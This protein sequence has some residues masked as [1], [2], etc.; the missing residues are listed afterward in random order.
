MASQTT[1]N[2]LEFVRALLDE[3]GDGLAVFAE[4]KL[5]YITE[6]YLR[7]IGR[8]RQ[9]AI[10]LN[11]EQI[12][13][14]I[15]EDDR[16]MVQETIETAHRGQ[17]PA[18]DFR[19]RIT[20]GGNVIWLEDTITA[21]Y[22][23]DGQ[24]LRSVI[25]SRD[26]SSRRQAEVDNLLLAAEN[27]RLQK[28]ESLGRM[29]T[30]LVHHFNNH[31]Q[32]VFANLE[33]IETDS[34]YRDRARQ[35]AEQILEVNRL[36]QTSL[37]QTTEVAVQARLCQLCSDQLPGLRRLLPTGVDLQADFSATGP[38]IRMSSFHF[39]QLLKRLVENASDAILSCTDEGT[40][41]LSCA[42]CQEQQIPRAHRFPVGW[43][44]KPGNYASLIVAD[45][46]C[47]IE[48]SEI[49]KVFEPFYSSKQL[50]RGMGL[51]LVLG[52]VQ[53]HEGCVTLESTPGQGTTFR[54]FLPVVPEP[55]S[56][57]KRRVPGVL[58][59]D[60]DQFVLD[61]M[62]ELVRYLG[63]RVHRASDGIEALQVFHEHRDDI[64]CVISDVNMPRM[65]GW[66]TLAALKQLDPPPFVILASGQALCPANSADRIALPDAFLGK[67]FTMKQLDPLL[68]QALGQ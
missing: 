10:G 67:P 59:V 16:M 50:G 20:K 66:Q 44:P 5:Q 42:V 19:Y 35:A 9:E 4:G 21:Q 1:T 52:L 48:P 32:A 17:L 54:V 51:A 6:G 63:Y 3:S 23:A 13:L 64:G 36:L 27:H 45:K 53:A 15:H 7:L 65:D 39:Q 33:L 18:F 28:F 14:Q 22:D 60:D 31:L 34:P 41:A 68:K 57:N 11:L 25:H 46:G 26:I 62:A 47:G 43:S 24:H 40:I 55:E 8:S 58:V 38:L 2:E 29:A 12:A 49:D 56:A 30:A 37:G 61:S